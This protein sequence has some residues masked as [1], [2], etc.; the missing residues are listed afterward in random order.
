[1]RPP[2][3]RP[4][5]PC[6]A[7]G[8]CPKKRPRKISVRIGYASGTRTHQRDFA[9]AAVAVARVLAQRPS[10]R[11]V[12]FRAHDSKEPV[13]NPGEFAVLDPFVE[14]IE[15]RDLVPLEGLPDE[16]VRFD[17]S[18]APLE[19]GNPF[20]EAKSEL[21]FFEAALVETC[22]I[23]SPTGPLRRV[24]QHGIN[25]L[26]AGSEDEWYR[27]IIELVDDPTRRRR[28]AHAAYLDVLWPFSPAR[29]AELMRGLLAQLGGGAE[30]ARA[31]ELELRR[32]T[33][34]GTGA[35]NRQV[36]AAP[37]TEII[38]AA[39]QLGNAEAT[40]IVPLHNYA[41]YV[42][43]A[44]ASV[45]SQTIPALDLIVIDDASSDASVEVA[46]GWAREHRDRFNRIVVL[47]NPANAGLALDP[48][49]RFRCRRNAVCAAARRRQPA[50]AGLRGG[51]PGGDPAVGG[52]LRLPCYPMLRRG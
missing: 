40:V 34:D 33:S 50:V 4:G 19:F 52:G 13:V 11:L 2:T 18:L 23:A 1:M 27:A 7:G 12:L 22:T 3:R 42:V 51:V 30:A 45:R 16:L 15:W 10:C 49:R 25:G 48:E 28:L 38:F 47:R 14:Q 43:E 9:E 31:F 39:D 8:C 17:I 37:E 5:S 6:A 29:R 41:G 20:C 46:A 21:K 44:L 36:L 35:G 32:G 24:V 26:L